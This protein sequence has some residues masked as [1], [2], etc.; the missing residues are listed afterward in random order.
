MLHI[1]RD[2]LFLLLIAFKTFFAR[3]NNERVRQSHVDR[4]V[5]ITATVRFTSKQEFA[6]KF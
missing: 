4:Y 1:K 2:S 5:R 3:I 6:N